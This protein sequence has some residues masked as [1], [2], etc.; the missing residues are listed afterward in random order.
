M[1]RIIA[2]LLGASLGACTSVKLVQR[3]GCWVRQ[4]V[5]WP[6]RVTEELGPCAPPTPKWADDRATRAAQECM[7]AADY[8]WHAL[9][10]AAWNRGE[11]VPA[12]AADS[13]L[14]QECMNA[15]ARAAAAESQALRDR[16]GALERRVGELGG[17]RDALRARADAAR[18]QHL[19]RDQ[20]V[21][22]RLLSGQEK[23]AEGLLAGEQKLADHLGAAASKP[24]QPAVATATASST[25]DGSATTDGA[26]SAPAPAGLLTAPARAPR[27]EASRRPA[28]AKQ[29]AAAP[30]CAPRNQCV[31]RAQAIAPEPPP[32]ASLPGARAGAPTAP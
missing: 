17:E 31:E 7:A 9:A 5:T 18:D 1:R 13:G 16:N 28:R 8:R 23:L 27:P 21:A 14:Y 30:R 32:A 19:A 2:A 20:A 12:R 15:P 3:D 26:T 6:A 24:A 25:S 22:D 4:T 29:K 10:V 11:Q